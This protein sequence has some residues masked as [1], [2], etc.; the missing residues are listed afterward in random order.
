MNAANGRILGL[1]VAAFYALLTLLPDSNTQVVSWP[2]VFVWQVGLVCPVLWLL[3]SM[4]KAEVVRSPFLGNRLD[5]CVCFGVVGLLLSTGFAEFPAQARWYAWVVLCFMAALYAL[6][7]SLANAEDRQRLLVGQGYLSVAFI[8]VSLGI[9]LIQILRPELSHLQTLRSLG[10]ATTLDWTLVRNWAPIGHANYVAG[11]LV[12][13]LPLLVALSVVQTGWRRGLW[14]I[15]VGLGLVDVYLTGSRGGW[16]GLL[17]AGGLAIGLLLLRSSLPRYKLVIASGGL[18]AGLLLLGFT[19]ARLRN[20]VGAIVSG[21]GGDSAYRVIAAV[22]GGRM[23]SQHSLVGAGLGSVPLLYQKYRPT[24]AGRETEWL[25]QLHST[26]VQLWAELGVWGIVTIVGTGG[27]LLYLSWKWARTV[28]PTPESSPLLTWSLL[29]GLLSYGAVSITDYQLDNVCISGTIVVFLVVLAAEFR[30]LNS[31]TLKK[32]LDPSLPQLGPGKLSTKNLLRFLGAGFL[33]AVMLW[34]AP[35]HQAW[36]LSNRGFAALSRQDAATGTQRL[37][38][39]HQLAPWEPYYPYQLGWYWGNLSLQTSDRTQQQQFAAQGIEWLQKGIKA[40]PYNEFGYTNLGWLLLNRDPKAATQAFLRSAALIPAKR[41]V[42]YGL[43]LSLLA[44]G[45]T[46]LAIAALTLETLRD[47]LLVT[48]P[49]WRSAGLQPIY[50]KILSKMAE[51]YTALLQSVPPGS[52]NRY[53]HQ[54]RGALFW[55][56]GNLNAAQADWALYGNPLSQS[57]LH[58]TPASVPPSSPAS[59][60]ELTIAAWLKPTQRESLLTQAWIAAT[61]DAPPAGLISA[62]VEGMGRS[63][64]FDQWVKQNAATRQYR[65]ERGGF[66]VISRHIDGPAPVDFLSVLENV[67]MTYFFDA[68]FHSPSY[69]PDLDTALQPERDRLLALIQGNY[70][71]YPHPKSLSPGRGTSIRLPFSQWEKGLGDEGKLDIEL[72]A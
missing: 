54:L 42:F 68:I 67:P 32:N 64:T 2:W 50:P 37:S 71:A 40:S 36:S 66:G 3:G 1:L 48:S 21:Q 23:G 62:L 14:A 28:S 4:G 31:V 10:S 72:A 51:R 16:F 13:G 39:S 53:L 56:Q 25:Y 15:G 45:R 47:P 70:S 46:D 12:L 58:L 52:F 34:L 59:A 22:A 27:L 9:W 17:V 65:R 18:M 29:I 33:V 19:N 44:Q 49:A 69:A 11:Y 43:G 6:S 8:L 41:G 7:Y 20:L 24:W 38:Q 57:V 5:G 26:P 30:V 63:S 55:W 60:G 61:R 35:I